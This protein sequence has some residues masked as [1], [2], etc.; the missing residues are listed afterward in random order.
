MT[1]KKSEPIDKGCLP[2]SNEILSRSILAIIAVDVGIV[3]A[4]GVI[5]LAYP[6][7]SKTQK[8]VLDTN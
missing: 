8:V 5:G 6:I 4:M 7:S 3:S 2:R 1:V